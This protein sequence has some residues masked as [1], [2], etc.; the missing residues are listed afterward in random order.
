[1]SA[2]LK[3]QVLRLLRLVVIIGFATETY[4]TPDKVDEDR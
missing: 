4:G 2:S 1:M 3:S